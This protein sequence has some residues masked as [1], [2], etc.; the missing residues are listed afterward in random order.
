IASSRV[1]VVVSGVATAV[2]VSAIIVVPAVAIV[3]AIIAVSWLV[4]IPGAAIVAISAVAISGAAAIVAASVVAVIPGANPNK[5]A[6]NKDARP[7]IAIRSA[8]VRRVVVVT[9]G[10]D[11]FCSN[12]GVIG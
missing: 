5:E 3:P 11:R 9:V 8:F 7:V 1:T 12:V 4:A 2:A 10:A 6:V